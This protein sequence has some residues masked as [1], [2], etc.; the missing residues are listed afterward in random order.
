VI[1]GGFLKLESLDFWMTPSPNEIVGG[2][3][4]CKEKGQ[5]ATTHLSVV[6]A[7]TNQKVSL[8]VA[9]SAYFHLTL[10][11]S[12]SLPWFFTAELFCPVMAETAQRKGGGK[13]FRSILEPHFEF[14]RELRQRRKFWG[15]IAELLFTEKGIR[16]TVYAPYLFYRR[17]IKRAAKSNWE[18][19]GNNSEA[20]PARP[21]SATNQ[22]QS[23]KS[24]L[25]PPTDFKRPDRSKINTDQE[26]T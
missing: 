21:N 1:S 10:T 23:R 6:V 8:L 5:N 24:P 19:P 18:S 4:R 13:P 26:F 22:R 14:I 2:K 9:Y 7:S 11:F 20:Q 17:K 16:V 3:K 15:Q 25:P 12:Y